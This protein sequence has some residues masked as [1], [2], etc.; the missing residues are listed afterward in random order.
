MS[1]TGIE[2][3]SYTKYSSMSK[4]YNVSTSKHLKNKNQQMCIQWFGIKF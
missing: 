4:K 3:R 2:A 1:S